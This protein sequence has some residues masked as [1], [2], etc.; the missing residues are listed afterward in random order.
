[1]TVSDA[2]SAGTGKQE[3][4]PHALISMQHF[5][6]DDCAEDIASRYERLTP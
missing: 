3:F 1:L 2:R 4:D 6:F 5:C